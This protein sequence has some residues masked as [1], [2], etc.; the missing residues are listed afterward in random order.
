MCSGRWTQ[1]FELR[2]REK[3]TSAESPRGEAAP[4]V[5]KELRVTRPPNTYL[6]LISY[7]SGDPQLAADAANAIAESYLEHTYDIRMRSSASLATFMERQLD[8]L[9]VKMERSSQALAAFEREL[10]VINPEEKTNILES[11][12]VQLNTEYTAAQ[13]DRAAPAGGLGIGPGRIARGRAG[14]SAGRSTAQAGGTS[15]EAREHFADVSAYYGANHP[16]YRRAKAQLDAGGRGARMPPG[17]TIARRVEVEY[18]ES[19]RREE[20]AGAGGGRSQDR[21]RPGE[22]AQLRVSGG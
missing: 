10:N 9:K 8:E 22:R 7:R 6:M 19:Q 16:E 4:I 14:V 2:L 1:R 13:A 5:L 3:Q 17:P 12:L 15:Q 21:I 20:M 18:R 11:R